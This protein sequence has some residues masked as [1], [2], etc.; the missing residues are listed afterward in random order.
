MSKTKKSNRPRRGKSNRR[1]RTILGMPPLLV[2]PLVLT[3]LVFSIYT[4]GAGYLTE[5]ANSCI[6]NHRLD[7]A[8]GWLDKLASF[9]GQKIECA[10]L[11]ARVA[12]KRGDY[13][14]MEEQLQ[15]VRELTAD[16]SSSEIQRNVERTKLEQ[17]TILP[18][19]ARA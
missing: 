18:W 15:L 6:L 7:D 14:T 16:M 13:A 9:Q 8:S 12:R 2:I 11:R 5:K 19:S 4:A 10:L 17:K 1:K 3:G